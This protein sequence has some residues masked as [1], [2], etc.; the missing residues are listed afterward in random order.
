[1]ASTSRGGYVV[2]SEIICLYALCNVWYMYFPCWKSYSIHLTWHWRVTVAHTAHARLFSTTK[3][4]CVTQCTVTQSR[5][6]EH[7]LVVK[8]T[9][10]AWITPNRFWQ[11]VALPGLVA[12]FLST[13]ELLCWQTDMGLPRPDWVPQGHS[14]LQ[15]SARPHIR[16]SVG[17]EKWS[18]SRVPT[19]CK[20]PTQSPARD[21]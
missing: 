17:D 13:I 12:P 11:N 4:N 20:Q 9:V 14:G 10:I 8:S 5:N 6:W 16:V 19:A 3:Q 15:Q 2:C 21:A 18:N 1:M 7:E